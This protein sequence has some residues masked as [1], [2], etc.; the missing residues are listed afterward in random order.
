ME[1]DEPAPST[2][3]EHGDELLPPPPAPLTL[4]GRPFK[5]P[6]KIACL[7]C[8][9]IKVKCRLPDGSAPTGDLDKDGGKCARCVRLKL[10]CEYKSAPRRG[11]KP[12]D[13]STSVGDG[14]ATSSSGTAPPLALPTSAALP[15]P[16]SG[17][18]P[19]YSL[20][21]SSGIAADPTAPAHAVP[22]PSFPSS[23]TASTSSVPLP[24]TWPLPPPNGAFLPSPHLGYPRTSPFGSY[25]PP[26]LAPQ[27]PSW[28]GARASHSS[29]ALSAPAQPSPASL[30]GS[31]TEPAQ[32]MLSLAEAADVKSSSFTA[33]R[34][35]LLHGLGKGKKPAIK[36]PD[37]VDMH[38]LTALEA[39]QLFQ[40]FHSQLN[41]FIVLFDAHLH[42]ADY[43]RTTSTALFTAILTASAKFFR[44]DL[45]P[46]LLSS[47]QQLVT[48]AMGGD[49]DPEIGL[50]QSLLILTYWKEPFDTSAW[51]RVGYAIRLGYQ[52]GL[53]HKRRQPLPEN[54]HEARVML[55]RE[56]TWIV[57]ICND[58]SY[59]LDDSPMAETRMIPTI[60]VD[61]DAWLA[62]TRRYDVRDDNEQA[63]SISL[64][65]IYPLFRTIASAPTRSVASSLASHIDGLIAELHTKYLDPSSPV[66]QSFTPAC[67]H[68]ARFHWRSARFELA[69]SCLLVAGVSDQL[70]L[71]N[72]MARASD[73]VECFEEA[74]REGILRYMQ[75]TIAVRMLAAGECLGKVF[76]QAS[77]T[78]QTSIVSYITRIYVA[79]SRAKEGSEDSAPAFIARFYKAVLHAL[80][81]APTRPPSPRSSAQ[82][83]M[84]A[85]GVNP[86][87]QLDGLSSE[88]FTG[89]DSL[90]EDLNRDN[91][92][93]DS[94]NSAQT[95]SSWAWLDSMLLQPPQDGAAR[96]SGT[97]ASGT[98]AP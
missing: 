28:P 23:S 12:K 86:F 30:A 32:T 60:D 68:K 44:P 81:G 34:P 65:K 31:T 55:D 75:D 15:D 49:G 43:V 27:P 83:G 22:S 6:N 59:K 64:V 78:L 41:C 33:D 48:R 82:H 11:R 37:P 8:R 93:W 53:H 47:A 77:P 74:V 58:N 94:L 9:T 89:L 4:G 14:A 54:E 25:A 29:P 21:P 88:I 10:P 96:A 2:A 92:Y 20:P 5:A 38:V 98:G 16:Y 42:T 97:G 39:E 45:Y 7:G 91:T 46:Q 51:L 61:I 71:V 72:F 80:G 90:V 1:D 84:G 50:L 87:E 70:V 40:L 76:S 26:P 35:S 52:L 85:L 17:S 19:M 66:Y 18:A 73:L 36:M 3:R 67:A 69:M 63:V 79:A 24:P 62:E 57:L 13:R 95:N 56:R